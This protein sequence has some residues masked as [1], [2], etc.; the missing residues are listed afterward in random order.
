[1]QA[2]RHGGEISL[3]VSS[4][5]V[6]CPWGGLVD[7]LGKSC[8]S[9]VELKRVMGTRGAKERVWHWGGYE[10]LWAKGPWL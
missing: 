1:M 9:P 8:C 2:E 6:A 5:L 10:G 3:L 7:G 4:L